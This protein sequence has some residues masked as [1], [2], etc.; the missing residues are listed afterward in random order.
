MKTPLLGNRKRGLLVIVSAPAGTGKTTLVKML[1]DEFPNIIQ[2]VSFTTRS[3]R[4]EEKN[5][6]D[7]HFV[8]SEEFEEMIKNNRFLEYALIYREYYGTDSQWVEKQLNSGKHVVLVIDTQGGLQLKG[9]IPGVFV[10]IEPPSME[11]LKQ[12]LEKR[13]TEPKAKIAERLEWAKKEIE[14]GRQY[15]YR[16]INDDLKTAYQV[17]RSIVIAEEHK[18]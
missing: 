4:G 7:Y 1:T 17:L 13:N 14:S 9:K 3:P 12:R 11:V 8:S 15:D 6:L 2:S 16:I 18:N 5:E 10:F